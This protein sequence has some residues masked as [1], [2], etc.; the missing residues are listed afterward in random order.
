VQNG[1]VLPAL[2][3]AKKRGVQIDVEHGCGQFQFRYRGGCD[4]AG[5]HLRHHFQRHACGSREHAEP[6]YL[7]WVLSKF[8]AL[9][10]SLEDVVAAATIKLATIIGKIP[11]LGALQV[12]A[13]GDVSILELVEGPEQLLD[14]SNNP[15]TGNAYLKAVQTVR[16]G[17]PFGRPHQ[18]PFAAN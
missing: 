4:P 17:V 5:P 16:E 13:P 11:K 7:P 3:A 2:L 12:G 8:L 6:P 10:F 9:G 1:K 18:L 14:T 15:N